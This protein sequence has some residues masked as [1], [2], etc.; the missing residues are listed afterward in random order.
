MARNAS[1]SGNEEEIFCTIN[2]RGNIEGISLLF[3]ERYLS[4]LNWRQ[5][6]LRELDR[7]HTQRH[8]AQSPDILS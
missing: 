6:N 4:G 8:S 1:E 7:I 2:N 3:A 5:S